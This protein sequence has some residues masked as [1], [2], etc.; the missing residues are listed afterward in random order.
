M[1]IFI[2]DV[3]HIHKKSPVE[4]EPTTSLGAGYFQNVMKVIIHYRF[5]RQFEVHNI[6]KLHFNSHF[7]MIYN[8]I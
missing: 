2:E 7:T 1:T 5:L 8:F 4:V 3:T 6:F